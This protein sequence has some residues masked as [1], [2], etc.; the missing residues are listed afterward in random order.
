MIQNREFIAS[1]L[2]LSTASLFF[3]ASCSNL[4]LIGS[5]KEDKLKVPPD[6][7][8]TV[9]G[10]ETIKGVNPSKPET[11]PSNK[12]STP[13]APVKKETQCGISLS[14]TFV[15]PLPS[16]LPNG[17]EEKGGDLRF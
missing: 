14:Q 5:K 15:Q 1:V 6:K 3:L 10:M 13:T 17:F 11:P 9:E 8:V 7:I 16:P 2:I 12:P 4:P